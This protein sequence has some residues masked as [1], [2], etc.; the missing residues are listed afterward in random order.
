MIKILLYFNCYSTS[1]RDTARSS[2][3][4]FTYHVS[5]T[6]Y[7]RLTHHHFSK[8]PVKLTKAVLR[9]RTG[10]LRIDFSA[11]L[12][13]SVNFPMRLTSLHSQLVLRTRSNHELRLRQR[14]GRVHPSMAKCI[15]HWNIL[16]SYICLLNTAYA[17]CNVLRSL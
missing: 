5:I 11:Y 12:V 4:I 13:R 3:G 16:T 7:L 14:R 2:A 8:F 6:I 10:V 15:W 9:S 1:S 17:K